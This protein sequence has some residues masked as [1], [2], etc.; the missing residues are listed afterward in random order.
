MTKLWVVHS[1]SGSRSTPVFILREFK[2]GTTLLAGSREILCLEQPE[3][4]NELANRTNESRPA[5]ADPN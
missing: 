4:F 5:S 3:I 2:A 1:H